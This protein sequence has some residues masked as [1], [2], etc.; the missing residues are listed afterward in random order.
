MTLANYPLPE[1]LRSRLEEVILTAK[2]HQV[3]MVETFLNRV[4]NPP[5]PKAVETSLKVGYLFSLQIIRLCV[6]NK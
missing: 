2:I 1:M 5:D 4:M 3:G 6:V